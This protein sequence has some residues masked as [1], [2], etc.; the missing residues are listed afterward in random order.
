VNALASPNPQHTEYEQQLAA[1]IGACAWEPLKYALY[2]W[3]GLDLRQW[4]IEDFEQIGR[5]LKDRPH[6][7]IQSAI[8]SGHGIGKGCDGAI[9]T[10]W[11]MSTREMTRGVVTANTDTQLRTKT[12]PELAKWHSLARNRHWFTCTA[13]ALYHPDYEKNWR[14][15]AI[16]W[17]EHNTE[18]FAGLHN[19]G[20]RIILWMDEAS[21][22]HDKVWEVSEGALTDE[23]TEILWLV[24]GNPTRTTGRFRDCFGRFQHRWMTRHIDS[25]TVEGTN[26]AQLDRYVQ[27]YGEDSDFVR[28]RVRGLFPSASSM[29]LIEASV[30]AEAMRREPIAGIRDPLIM[31]VD[32]ARGGDDR[33]VIAYR[34][35]LDGKSIPPVVVPGSE[36]RDSMRMVS[37]VVDLAT[38]S[39]RR[40]RPDG[41]I[42]DETGVGGPI[43]DRLRQI[44]GDMAQVYGVNFS[45]ASPDPKFGNMRAY[46]WWKL[47]DWLRLGG[48]LPNDPDIERDLCGPEYFHDKRDRLMLESKDDIK[49]R[50]LPSPDLGDGYAISFAYPIQPREITAIQGGSGRCLTDYDPYSRN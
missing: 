47:R 21:A 25:R 36:A 41:I 12:W 27:D 2:N 5:R 28:V 15:D 17:S 33:F 4:Q 11:A 10:H 23:A 37:K 43:V 31:T 6:D 34:R 46:M 26:K 44:L 18:A 39:D 29:Q 16:P 3:P 42:V 45:T 38:T 35:G 40:M 49:D 20:Y 8:A 24:R 14:I 19:K 9:L 48:C 50:G 30:V 22:I 7:P 32:V 1:D 13:T